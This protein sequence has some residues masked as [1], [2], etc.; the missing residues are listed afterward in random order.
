[1]VCDPLFLSHHA[2]PIFLGIWLVT[3]IETR[4]LRFFL[5]ERFEQIG[6][7]LLHGFIADLR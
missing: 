5:L 4:S 3:R 6:G 7:M 2:S 1:M